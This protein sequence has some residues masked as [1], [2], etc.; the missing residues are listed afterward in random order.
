MRP[1]LSSLLT[2]DNLKTLITA[3]PSSFTSIISY[4]R[5]HNPDFI[6]PGTDDNMVLRNIF[7]TSAYDKDEFSKP[8]F[9]KRID[10]DTCPYCNR[11]YI[12]YLSD[13]YIIK[14]QL[15]HFY[16]KSIYPFFGV[17]YY[18]LIPC[19]QTCN[20][21]GVKEENDPMDLDLISPYLLDND[22]F[23]FTYRVRNINFLNP[24]TDKYSVEIRFQH[25]IAGHL[26][27]FK[28]DLLYAQHTDHVLELIMKSKVEYSDRY[29]KYLRSYAGFKFSDKEID[30]MILGNYSTAAEVHKR[31]LAKLYQ[32]I[33]KQL[34]LI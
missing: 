15:D 23:K 20:G 7:I 26:N 9:I 19:C 27:V 16:P 25:A 5:L 30:R 29:R 33:G 24:L 34:G 17:S 11:S 22:H 31:P 8:D 10:L 21:I 4:I 2:G 14:P 12:Y 18:N 13:R 32:D 1:Y 28:L 3:D 6:I